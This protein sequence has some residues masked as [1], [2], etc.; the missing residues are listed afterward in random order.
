M[1]IDLHIH[2]KNSDGE[3]SL[4]KLRDS[5]KKDKVFGYLSIT[6]HN[7]LTDCEVLKIGNNIWIPGIEVSSQYNGDSI[8]LT[9]YSIEPHVTTK[10]EIILKDIVDGYNRRAQKQYRKISDLGY[11][12][13]PLHRIRNSELP[14]PIYTYDIVHVLSILLGIHNDKEALE[15]CRNNGN[16]L[17]VKEKNFMP[18]IVDVIKELHESGF[19]VFWAH[20]GTRFLRN[21]EDNEFPKLLKK[22]KGFGLDGIEAF[23]TTHT[24]KQIQKFLEYAKN[25][26]LLISA[27]SDY[28]GPER[29]EK[30][31][32][33]EDCLDYVKD[34]LKRIGVL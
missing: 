5:F 30:R 16:L 22:F 15:W 12:L 8:H 2:S 32:F 34:T 13:P 6:D 20:P 17:F 14:G 33:N 23:Y 31:F 3:D 29:A 26:D 1:Y 9:A 11:S 27:G 19:L 21:P 18:D 7:Y 4:R 28:H 25:Y 24:S 10:L